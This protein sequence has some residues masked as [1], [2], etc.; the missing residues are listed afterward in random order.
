VL[1]RYPF[2]ANGLHRIAGA[3]FLHLNVHPRHLAIHRLMNVEAT[4]IT[5]VMRALRQRGVLA[6]PMHDGLIVPLSA[7]EQARDLLLD[8]GERI[9]KVTL[10][11]TIDRGGA[12]CVPA[13][14]EVGALAG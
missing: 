8:A 2:I 10:R 5:E 12:D 7:A 9:A 6:L 1:A 13:R 4:V 3:D 14:E 11:L